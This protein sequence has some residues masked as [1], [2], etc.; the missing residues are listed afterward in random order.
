[1]RLARVGYEH[2]AGVLESDM[3][4]WR[5]EGLPVAAMERLPLQSWTDGGRKVLDVRRSREWNDF[6]LKGA[7]HIPLAQLPERLDELDRGAAW[8]VVC[9]SGY[10]SSI[11]GSVLQ[12]AGFTRVANGVGGMDAWR[13]AGRLLEVGVPSEA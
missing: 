4:R 6:H 10:R 3:A 5:A 2:V 8:V 1:M 12:R 13:A 9:G 7:T 11:A